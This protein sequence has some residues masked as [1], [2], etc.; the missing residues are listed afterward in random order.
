MDKTALRQ[1]IVLRLEEEL[2]LL[3]AAA[4]DAKAEAIDAESRQE[5][6]YDMRGQTAAYLAEGQARLAAELREAIGSYQALALERT[7]GGGTVGV[8]A[9]VVLEAGGKRITY[10]FGP[11]RGGVEVEIGGIP[12]TVITAASPVGSR[13][14]GRR[15]G[16]SV[17]LPGQRGPWLIAAVE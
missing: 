2:S 13:I 10:F 14:F 12:V 17:M 8:G 16:E 5:G 3:L 9:L 11:A 15:A 7:A 4:R 6:K 1:A